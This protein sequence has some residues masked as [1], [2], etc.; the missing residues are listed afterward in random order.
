MPLAL[1]LSWFLPLCT[2]G[3]AA[4]TTLSPETGL[5]ESSSEIVSHEIVVPGASGAIAK[6]VLPGFTIRH[7]AAE[8]HLQFSVSDDRGRLLSDLSLKDFRILDNH[9]TVAVVRDFS[10]A[11]DLPLQMGF[12]LDVSD[13]MQRNL[14]SER[15]TIQYAITNL[16]RSQ[17]DHAFL[18]TF[19]S[20][21]TLRQSYTGDR[22]ALLQAASSVHQMGYATYLYDAL[23]RA[24]TEQFSTNLLADMAQRVLFVV[25]DG[26]DTGS[27]HSL[28]DAISIA[29]RRG[30]Q[31]YS[32][33]LHSPRLAPPGDKVLKRLAEATG[34]QLFVVGS[35][36]DLP[37][38]W[39]TIEQQMRNQF[40]VSFQPVEPT[41]GFHAVQIELLRNSNLR[42]HSRQGYFFGA[43]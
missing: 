7:E 30:V 12:L 38:L 42:A 31:I 34:G 29:Q 17:S 4:V 2:A 27:I 10:R 6:A 36:K 21:T 15:R 32:L 20:D 35:D 19:A 33:S 26:E 1:L 37:G 16:L 40:E 23:Y 39:A 28:E 18:A 43:P 13:S 41:P 22:D 5:N 11:D 25:S 8:V 14:L 9:R 24:C 3:S